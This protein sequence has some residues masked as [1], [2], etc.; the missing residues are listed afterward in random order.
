KK[1]AN[2]KRKA[3][4]GNQNYGSAKQQKLTAQMNAKYENQA[5]LKFLSNPKPSPNKGHEE[6]KGHDRPFIKTSSLFRNN[7]EIPDVLSPAVTQVKEKV[8]TS[9]SFQEVDLHPHLVATLN[10]VLNISSMTSVQKQTIPV[11]M[12]GKDAVVRSQTGSG[13]TLAYGIPVIQSLQAVQP[14]I[15]VKAEL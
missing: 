3:S 8:F 6:H 15:K 11:L 9:N 13:K 4:F 14:K 10:K 12:A 7:P 1:A 5:E 2:G